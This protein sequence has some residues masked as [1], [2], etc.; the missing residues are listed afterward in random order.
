MLHSVYLSAR[1][2]LPVTLVTFDFLLFFTPLLLLNYF[3]FNLFLFLEKSGGLKPPPAPPSARSLPFGF[4]S[5]FSKM[6]V[7]KHLYVRLVSLRRDREEELKAHLI[8]NS[9]GQIFPTTP[10]SMADSNGL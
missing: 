4:E 6:L 5:S 1:L 10:Q 9:A 2:S 8:S 7:D 3:L